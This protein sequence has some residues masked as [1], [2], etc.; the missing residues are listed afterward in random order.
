MVEPETFKDL[1][2]ILTFAI[3]R[4][5]E[6]ARAYSEMKDLA[7]EQSLRSVLEEL[8]TEERKHKLLLEDVLEG[9]AR[10]EAPVYVADLK[11]SDYVQDEPLG[12]S[13]TI[14]DLLI[15]AA[16]KEQKAADLYTALA[17]KYPEGQSQRLFGFLASQEKTHKLRLEIEYEKYFLAEN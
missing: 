16:K 17:S 14:Q 9:K 5:E 6:A 1:K 11:I 7:E 2:S 3:R 4:E 15:F 8:E 12:P 10:P 13:A